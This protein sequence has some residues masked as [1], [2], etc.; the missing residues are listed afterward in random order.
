[1]EKDI[2]RVWKRAMLYVEKSEAKDMRGIDR[3]MV[4]QRL[5]NVSGEISDD[6]VLIRETGT[7]QEPLR[8]KTCL[9]DEL[10]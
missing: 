3:S 2:S 5:M 8:V 1:M 10:Q 9:A 7:R 4:S 6:D